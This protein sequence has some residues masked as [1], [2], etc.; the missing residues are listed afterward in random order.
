MIF[1]FIDQNDDGSVIDD[2]IGFASKMM[3]GNSKK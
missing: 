2:I 1:D 3:Q